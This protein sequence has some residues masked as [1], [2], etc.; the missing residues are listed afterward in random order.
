MV[1]VYELVT[2][3]CTD[4]GK[5]RE[6][7]QDNYFLNQDNPS[8]ITLF[9][10]AGGHS[11]GEIASGYGSESSREIYAELDSLL[12]ENLANGGEQVLT[13]IALKTK[14]YISECVNKERVKNPETKLDPLTTYVGLFLN[15][16]GIANYAH[17]GDSRLYLLR[18]GTLARLTD[19]HNFAFQTL[20]TKAEEEGK[21]FDEEAFKNHH[22]NNYITR[23]I[24]NGDHDN[25]GNEVLVDCSYVGIQEGDVYLLCSDGLTDML[26]D[27]TRRE[28]DS[29]SGKITIKS[30][31]EIL[32][33]TIKPEEKVSEKKLKQCANSLI[34]E[35]NRAG[36]QDNITVILARVNGMNESFDLAEDAF[37]RNETVQASSETG[38]L[39][40]D[41]LAEN[42]R[43]VH[44]AFVEERKL[45]MD[46][47][48]TT[49]ELSD[50]HVK[51]TNDVHNLGLNLESYQYENANLEADVTERTGTI[52]I[53]ELEKEGLSRKV[54]NYE[55]NPHKQGKNP[56]ILGLLAGV[57]L[58]LGVYGGSQYWAEHDLG[59]NISDVH[60][61]ITQLHV[62]DYLLGAS[63]IK[64]QYTLGKTSCG[65]LRF[66]VDGLNWEFQEGNIYGNLEHFSTAKDNLNQ[67][68][69]EKCPK[70]E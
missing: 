48:R 17:A 10:G 37:F 23:S 60:A 67:F 35:A 49:L 65:D 38:Q 4:N 36:G 29:P 34:Y 43:K 11:G 62:E 30:I 50:E 61:S 41:V 21:P 53:L 2:A 45:R 57:A 5:V 44:A 69:D 22:M 28:L 20:K 42:Y 15:P 39:T 31:E 40:Y 70:V 24:S 58:T 1:Y 47:E 16:I 59:S 7:N 12:G 33:Q 66:E 64:L 14:K 19:D 51:L 32:N 56:R 6:T 18:E 13:T 63:T 9:D 27:K 52:K 26:N 8:L 55:N 54:K 3:A 68:V 46:L 25:H